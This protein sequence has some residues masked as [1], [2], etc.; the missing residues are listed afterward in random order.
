[1]E[2]AIEAKA[3]QNIEDDEDESEDETPIEEPVSSEE[4]VGV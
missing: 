3:Q 4:P 2:K 1:V